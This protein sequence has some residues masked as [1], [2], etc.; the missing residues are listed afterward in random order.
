[1]TA[2]EAELQS[3]QQLNWLDDYQFSGNPFTVERK[4]AFLIA[5]RE[6]GSVFHAAQQSGCSR[7]AAYDWMAQD[8][9]FAEAVA[10]IREDNDDDLEASVYKRAFKSDLLAMFYLKAHRPKFRDKVSVDLSEVQHQVEQLIEKLGGVNQLQ[11]PPVTTDYIDTHYSQ[12]TAEYQPEHLPV[13]SSQHIT[14]E[15]LPNS[16]TPAN[17]QKDD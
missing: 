17:Q 15:G 1:M 12:G 13:G 2:Q 16:H 9:Q 8:E 3:T 14:A 10:S 6:Y 4:C 7:R 5:F 11:L